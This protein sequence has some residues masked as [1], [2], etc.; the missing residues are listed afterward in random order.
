MTWQG[1]ESG[2]KLSP[3]GVI[4]YQETMGRRPKW[5]YIFQKWTQ[6]QTLKLFLS[7]P[8]FY[9]SFLYKIKKPQKWRCIYNCQYMF[10]VGQFFS[11]SRRSRRQCFPRLDLIVNFLA[12]ESLSWPPAHVMPP[13]SFCRGAAAAAAA[14]RSR[15]G[16]TAAPPAGSPVTPAQSIPSGGGVLGWALIRCLLLAHSRCCRCQ[17]APPPRHYTPSASV[18]PDPPPTAF[19]ALLKLPQNFE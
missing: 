13:T 11:A 1:T 12:L 19:W 15:F 14:D 10:W 16:M 17:S 6:C 7:F 9:C 18:G 5:R 8:A 3:R 2:L 4:K